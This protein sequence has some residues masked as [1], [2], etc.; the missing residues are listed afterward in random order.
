MIEFQCALLGLHCPD[1]GR[2]RSGEEKRDNDGGGNGSALST[3]KPMSNTRILS[4]GDPNWAE[5]DSV[6][7]I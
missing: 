2:E 7:S 5:T 4:K 1:N 3:K 6:G